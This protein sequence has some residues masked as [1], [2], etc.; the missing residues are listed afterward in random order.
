MQPRPRSS[1]RAVYS[2][3][4]TDARRSGVWKRTRCFSATMRPAG[5]HLAANT[6]LELRWPAE[7]RSDL[8]PSRGW[9]EFGPAAPWPIPAVQMPNR[10][11]CALGATSAHHW[12]E[13]TL[14]PMTPV[15][16]RAIHSRRLR[17]NRLDCASRSSRSTSFSTYVR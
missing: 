17:T 3:K 5:T 9:L 15:R 11:V 7:A 8:G 6:A 2:A 4:I 16:L 12:P 10:H 1:V 13:L 14:R